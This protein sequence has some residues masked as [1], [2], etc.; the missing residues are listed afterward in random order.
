[1]TGKP[2]KKGLRNRLLLQHITIILSLLISV[3]ITVAILLER[4]LTAE[5]NNDLRVYNEHCINN[6]QQRISYLFESANTFSK[7]PFVINALLDPQGRADYLPKLINSFAKNDIHAVTMV[8][9]DESIAYSTLANPS[10]YSRARYL[11]VAL[12]VGEPRFYVADNNNL[13][14]IVPIEFYNTTQGALVI[15]YD[16]VSIFNSILPRE[17]FFYRLYANN[18][19]ITDKN[20]KASSSY[21]IVR[22][23]ATRSYFILDKLKI[24]VELGALKSK[25][26]E[27]IWDAI[28]KL[29]LIGIFFIIVAVFIAIRMGHIVCDPILTLCR[30]V[31]M[32]SED[33][34]V[35]CSPLGTKDE[36]EFLAGLFDKRTE[37]LVS[38]KD[39]LQGNYELLQEEIVQRNKAEASLKSAYDDLEL[40][41]RQ[42]T[43]EL[44]A[45]KEAAEASDKAKSA[46]LANMSHEIRTPMNSILGFLELVLD[47]YNLSETDRQYLG[48]ARK[49]AR[50]LLGLINDILDV[51]KM[52]SGKMTLELKPFNLNDLLRSVYQ[53]FEVNVREK[54]LDFKHNIAPTLAGNFTGDPLRL[55]Q[56]IINLAGNA[57]KFTERGS[58][59]IEVRPHTEGDFIHFAI[60]DTGI[61]IPAERLEGIFEAFTQADGSMTRRFGGTG[62]GTTISKQLVEMMGG[63]IWVESEPGKGS[64]FHFIV[65]VKRTDKY[66]QYPVQGADGAGDGIR[67]SRPHRAFR[68]LVA[69]D[70][71][72]NIVL[73]KTRLEHQGHTV[74][75]ARDGIEA[76]ERFK[77]DDVDIILMDIQMP[78]M[79][80]LEATQHIRTLE[81]QSSD[82]HIPIIALT[83][84]VMEEE[85]STYVH[86]GIDAVIGKPVQFGQLFDTIEEITPKGVGQVSVKPLVEQETSLSDKS[87]LLEGIDVEKG[88]ETWMDPKVYAEA[89]REF[90]HKYGNAVQGIS[91]LVEDN[92][93]ESATRV[94]HAIK[95]V[96]GNLAMPQVYEVCREIERAIREQHI[97]QLRGLLEQFRDAL[98]RVVGSIGRFQDMHVQVAAHVGVEP[99]MPMVRDIL[100]RMMQ[101]I[102]QYSPNEVE[103][104]LIELQRHVGVEQIAQIKRYVQELNFVGARLQTVQFARTL[105]IDVE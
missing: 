22:N 55:R 79:D 53:M 2:Q 20:F 93:I 19:R 96:S 28:I 78:R 89:L 91:S 42:R 98:G 17:A 92:D 1:M 29:F 45:A 11:R 18:V 94:V 95:G 58:V 70:I 85:R 25:Y 41:V 99:D 24:S 69:E 35:K 39:K 23:Y 38:A 50:A 88:I 21:I 102:E 57:I 3:I 62:L 65:D 59:S 33:E 87:F 26:R 27:V 73:L 12:A 9:F 103:P 68:I 44:A 81:G 8:R 48:I 31:E 63:R 90:S 32:A 46:F 80:G 66:S 104:L 4:T 83:A 71:D 49:S 6:L 34:V 61:G 97:D 60:T 82:R 75:V 74:V 84:S 15:E 7:N 37:Q 72:E 40:R 77:S 10:D 54:G 100:K 52:E 56:I 105:E 43:A 13:I 76:V 47:G 14:Y 101:A 16:L 64:V 36:L 86:K 30:R 5:L 51:S 67:Q